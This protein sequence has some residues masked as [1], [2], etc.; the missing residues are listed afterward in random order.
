MLKT[1]EHSPGHVPF[2][3]AIYGH[4]AWFIGET[5]SRVCREARSGRARQHQ[6]EE[7]V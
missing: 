1:I 5:P 3:P 4:K 6:P 2:M 7:D